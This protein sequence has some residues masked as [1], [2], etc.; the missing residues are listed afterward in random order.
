MKQIYALSPRRLTPSLEVVV[1]QRLRANEF[2]YQWTGVDDDGLVTVCLI[3]RDV[4][5]EFEEFSARM[6]GLCVGGGRSVQFRKM[7]DGWS[8]VEE[9]EWVS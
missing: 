7:D 8:F 5:R 3:E 6:G 1:V 4:F 2:V 9:A